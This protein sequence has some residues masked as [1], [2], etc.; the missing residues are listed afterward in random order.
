MSHG[1]TT[2]CEMNI[3]LAKCYADDAEVIPMMEIFVILW[4]RVT[5]YGKGE[6]TPLLS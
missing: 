1:S 6:V 5:G 4:Y 3:E 2:F